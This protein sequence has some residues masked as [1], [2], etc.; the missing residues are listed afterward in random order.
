MPPGARALN[1]RGVVG[2]V[3]G[4]STLRNRKLLGRGP[5]RAID[6]PSGAPYELD[7]GHPVLR[8]PAT[9]RVGALRG[10]ALQIISIDPLVKHAGVEIGFELGEGTVRAP[11]V[12][13]L[14]S[15][16]T[17]GWAQTAPPLAIEYADSGQDETELQA[18]PGFSTPRSR[19]RPRC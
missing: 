7:N 9:Q 8:M 2:M 14:A 16:P 18:K 12:S 10:L 3:P 1:V 13:V 11:D 17:N 4:M 15:A 5:F 6:L 19:I